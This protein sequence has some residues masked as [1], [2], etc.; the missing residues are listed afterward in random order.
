MHPAVDDAG[1]R[2]VSVF[3]E[4]CTTIGDDMTAVAAAEFRDKNYRRRV[5]IT[6]TWETC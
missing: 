6:K 4:G 5:V 3:V 1:V 2:R